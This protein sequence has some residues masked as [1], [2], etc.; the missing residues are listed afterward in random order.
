M[1]SAQNRAWE[2]TQL[3]GCQWYNGI[4]GRW[5]LEAEK[6]QLKS[7][8]KKE[9]MSMWREFTEV[10]AVRKRHYLEIPSESP[11]DSS[12]NCEPWKKRAKTFISRKSFILL[13]E[14]LP[15]ML[16]P[17]E[18][19]LA[20]IKAEGKMSSLLCK[21]HSE[22]VILP[23]LGGGCWQ[24]GVSLSS[25]WTAC[26]RNQMWIKKFGKGNRGLM[27]IPLSLNKIWYF[28]IIALIIYIRALQIQN[29]KWSH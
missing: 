12:Q 24:G 9:E 26:H 1:G 23:M 4:F 22:K 3:Q 29:A 17:W 28:K 19:G 20:F 11:Q 6:R 5:T 13:S 2:S 15:G 21:E 10:A 27:Y 25:H 7:E 16:I 18:F 14:F 8:S